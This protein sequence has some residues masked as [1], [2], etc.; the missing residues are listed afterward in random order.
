M[1]SATKQ[2]NEECRRDTLAWLANRP[3]LKFAVDAVGNGVRRKGHDYT[4]SEIRIAL[5]FLSEF[6]DPK[7][8]VERTPEPMGSTIFYGIT[9][10]GTLFYER[11]S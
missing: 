4:D 7:P 11:N 2:R 10:A 5:E 1:E 9:A 8:Y 6:G 3:S